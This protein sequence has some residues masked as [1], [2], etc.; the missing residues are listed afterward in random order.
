M[1]AVV[2]ALIFNGICYAEEPVFQLKKCTS[3]PQPTQMHGA[4]V[5]GNRLYVFGGEVIPEAWSDKAYSAVIATDGSLGQ[6]KPERTMPDRRSYI[7]QAVEVSNNRIYICAG[8]VAPEANSPEGAT[9]SSQDVLWTSVK[10]DGTLDEWKTSVPFPGHAVLSAA[11]ASNDTH[12]F[13]TGG[14]GNMQ[15]RDSV[16]VATFGPDGAPTNWKEGRKLPIGLWFHGA[17]I[18]DDGLYVWG[19]LP[20]RENKVLNKNVYRAVVA[21]DGTLGEWKVVG[22]QDT[23]VYSA[24]FSGI[25]DFLLSVGGRYTVGY[26]TAA[27]WYSN[28][29][30][31]MPQTFQVL[32]SNLEA[33]L[34]HAV[35]LDK[36]QGLVYITG[37]RF[38]PGLDINV[39][40]VLDTVQAF[41]IP[42][43]GTAN[44][45][46]VPQGDF[47]KLNAALA[48]ARQ[49]GKRVL[50]VF[51]SPQ[52]PATLRLW[53]TV[54]N[55]SQFKELAKDYI[56]AEL[57]VSGPDAHISY[58]YSIYKVPSMAIL[59]GSGKLLDKTTFVRTWEDT[60]TFLDKQ[61]ANL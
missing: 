44:S 33:R 39:G 21:K 31:G 46:G 6:W 16:N 37:G 3:L 27:I 26:T 15:P 24:A 17:A 56:L 40:R 57:D 59:D 7:S 20:Q 9:K 35:G 19:G 54:L 13:I 38:R 32:Q 36:T 22:S 30:D 1:P 23:P 34:Y 61:P 58:E 18:M 60:K 51:H 55:T 53:S 28:L 12:L 5:V 10:P 43:S 48:E 52:V 50:V 4:A 2:T 41:R 45:S 29:Q 14:S 49:N 47:K 11:T 25:N 8:S 42:Q